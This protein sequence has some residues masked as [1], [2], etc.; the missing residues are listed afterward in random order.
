MA[1]EYGKSPVALVFD[2]PFSVHQ[3]TAYGLL[4]ITDSK[5]RN[6]VGESFGESVYTLWILL[7]HTQHRPSRLY[8]FLVDFKVGTGTPQQALESVVNSDRTSCFAYFDEQVSRPCVF[9]DRQRRAPVRPGI[10]FSTSLHLVISTCHNYP[11]T[12]SVI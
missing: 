3:R 11:Y 7:F 4:G 2:S 6:L 9:A 8:Y 1:T 5:V 12:H 10:L